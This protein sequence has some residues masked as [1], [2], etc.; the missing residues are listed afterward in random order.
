MRI[1]FLHVRKYC[2]RVGQ[3]ESDHTKKMVYKNHHNWFPTHSLAEMQKVVYT[4]YIEIQCESKKCYI[5]L[6]TKNMAS[7][8]VNPFPW[9]SE[10]PYT[11]STVHTGKHSTVEISSLLW[12]AA[13][14][15]AAEEL[16]CFMSPGEHSTIFEDFWEC[17]TLFQ[18]NTF[19]G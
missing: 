6:A 14:K 18:K 9:S 7:P 8:P 4:G 12:I 10:I 16:P 11:P 1:L 19:F 5:H 13:K 3:W 17:I 15:F 2:I